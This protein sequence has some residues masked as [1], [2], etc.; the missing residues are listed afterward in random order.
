V[1]TPAGVA[2]VA[3]AGVANA[4]G[5]VDSGAKSDVVLPSTL[6]VS[7]Y[8]QAGRWAFMADITRTNWSSL[9]ELRIKFDSG[10]SDSVVTL[11]LVDTYRTSF[12][13]TYKPNDAWILRAGVALDQSPVQNAS[14]RTP[15]LPDA[16]RTW[17]AIG[18]GLQ[19]SPRLSVDFGYAHINMDNSQV[20]KT[21]TPT[22]ENLSRG[23]LS[24]DYTGT[25]QVLSAQARWMF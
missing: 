7:F 13:M 10:Q 8:Q 9:P 1:P 5:I 16:D 6:S 25:I 21:A 19:V 4:L 12:G 11:N 3:T 15:R 20:R 14:D 18:A 24:V 2:G 22:N 17:V 23:N